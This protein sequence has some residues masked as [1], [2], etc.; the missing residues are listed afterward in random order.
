MAD[1]KTLGDVID[2]ISQHA[3]SAPD[4]QAQPIA[5]ASVDEPILTT[6]APVV[7]DAPDSGSIDFTEM[8]LDVVAEKTGYPKEI[9]TVDMDLELDL[10]IDSI[11][12]VEIFSAINDENPGMPEVDP[13]VMAEIKTLGD[14]IA[15]IERSLGQVNSNKTD[16]AT[17][18]VPVLETQTPEEAL[19]IGRYVLRETPVPYS[20]FSMPG[21][22]QADHMC[23]IDDETGTGFSI[24][25][26]LAK[27]LKKKQHQS[28][29]CYRSSRRLR[30]IDF[31]RRFTQNC[32]KTRCH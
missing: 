22:T 16:S 10:G 18:T 19:G 21:L 9:L 26:A 29:G 25:D 27:E 4:S 23:I 24:G 2:F 11:K 12:R 32:K 5:V 3:P 13:A 17:A 20:G 28:L 31:F 30:W 1:I 6:P 7:P 8:L 15:F 14:V